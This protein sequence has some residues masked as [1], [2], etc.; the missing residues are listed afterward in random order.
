MND[1][2]PVFIQQNTATAH[3]D[4]DVPD[5]A[6]VFTKFKR[7]CELLFKTYYKSTSKEEKAI[8]IVL[9]LGDEGDNIYRT[10]SWEQVTDSKDP[11]KVLDKFEK[12]CQP[13]TSHR[14]YRYTLM[15]MRQGFLPVDTF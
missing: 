11:G 9:W 13:I 4:L 14:L 5:K 10:F 1:P 7:K 8:Y 6:A 15:N 12:H 2:N 3:M